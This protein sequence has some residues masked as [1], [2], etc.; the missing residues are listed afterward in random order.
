M[1]AESGSPPRERGIRAPGHELQQTSRFTPARAGNTAAAWARRWAVA[2]H[3]RASGEYPAPV[4]LRRIAY[5]SPPRER[6]I[7]TGQEA[8]PPCSRFTPARAGNTKLF[9]PGVSWVPVHPRASGEYECPTNVVPTLFGSP[10]RERGIPF[11]LVD[12]NGANRFT[13]ARAGNTA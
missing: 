9:L 10:P 4:E 1:P 8:G 6:G 3:P 7:H 12:G 5:G 13:P 11:T 2:V